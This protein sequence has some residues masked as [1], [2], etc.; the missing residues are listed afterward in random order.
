MATRRAFLGTPLALALGAWRP[1]TAAGTR[2][3]LDPLRPGVYVARAVN[4]E[5][6]R[7]NAGA[8]VPSLVHVTCAGV[9]VVDPGPH[10]AWGNALLGAIRALTAQ[11]V[12]WVV[13][14]HAHPENVLA[15]AAFDA[16]R[17]RPRFLASPATA[18]LMRQRCEDC[19][20]RL[21]AQLGLAAMRG[22]AL[23]LPEPALRDGAWLWTG[24]TAWQ[25]QVHAPAHSGS[26][27]VLFAPQLRLLC[28]G[29]LAYRERVPEMQEASLQ[30]WRHALRQL[31]A[32]PADIVVAT[33]TGTPAQTLVPTLA[34]LDALAH[35]IGAALAAGR[36]ATQASDAVA[37]A[38]FRH[39]RHFP[40][41]HPLN[42][43]RAWRQLEDAWLQGEPPA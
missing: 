41:R 27:T 34:Y 40:T 29:G 39:W 11:P 13:N 15:N 18:A 10:A 24:A 9:L 33:A 16:V 4:A 36:D 26:D 12:R 43:Q 32:L 1:A 37:A 22:T 28:A 21:G 19:L 3:V 35:G 42:L 25:V 7:A 2:V 38:R 6:M 23:V 8:V 14:T 20:A 30:G 31:L 17:P 5:A